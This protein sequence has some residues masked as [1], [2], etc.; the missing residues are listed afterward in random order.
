MTQSLSNWEIGGKSMDIGELENES[1]AIRALGHL[2]KLTQ[3]FLWD[4]DSMETQGRSS[5]P[6]RQNSL[7]ETAVSFALDQFLIVIFS[8]QAMYLKPLIATSY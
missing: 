4:D 1:P 7:S 3:V 8:A 6:K 5:S 2:F